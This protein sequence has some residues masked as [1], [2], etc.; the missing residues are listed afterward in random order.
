MVDKVEV[1]KSGKG[2][3]L[4][5]KLSDPVYG[6]IVLHSDQYDGIREADSRAFVVARLL[7]LERDTLPV[8]G[9]QGCIGQD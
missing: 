4:R 9:G 5:I 7:G 8:H 1:H 6:L 3:R 2:Y